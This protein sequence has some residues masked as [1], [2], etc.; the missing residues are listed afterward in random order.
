MHWRYF[1]TYDL[2][3][4]FYVYL[5]ASAHLRH[6]VPFWLTG[7]SIG[8]SCWSKKGCDPGRSPRCHSLFFISLIFSKVSRPIV[9]DQLHITAASEPDIRWSH[10][11][12]SLPEFR[13]PC[14]PLPETPSEKTGIQGNAFLPHQDWCNIRVYCKKFSDQHTLCNLCHVRT[15]LY[16]FIEMFPLRSA[17]IIRNP[18][19][20]NALSLPL[21]PALLWFSDFYFVYKFILVFFVHIY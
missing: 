14:K 16:W 10:L 15:L 21:L 2:R 13:E 18:R 9:F 20:I 4:I 7:S 8:I 17:I 19:G 3:E 12:V 11:Q 1:R 6:S 5:R